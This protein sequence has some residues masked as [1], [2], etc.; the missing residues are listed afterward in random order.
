MKKKYLLLSTFSG[1]L[2]F[3][4]WST[5]PIGTLSLI[6]FIPL[7]FIEYEQL[8]NKKLHSGRT[9]FKYS[10]LSFFIWNLLSTWW[11]Y[12]ATPF[13]AAAAVILNSLFY[14]VVFWIYHITRKHL[15]NR[16][17]DIAFITYWIAFEYIYLNGEISWVWLILGNTFA[18]TPQLVQWYEYTGT[19]GGSLWILLT[20]IFIFRTLECIISDNKCKTIKIKYFRIIA[21]ISLLFIPIIISLYIFKNYKEQGKTAEFVITQPNIDPYND[22]FSGNISPYDQVLLST[23]TAKP[24]ISDSTEYLIAPE[25]AIP[26]GIWENQLEKNYYLKPFFELI[27]TFPSLNIVTGATTYINYKNIKKTATAR[28]II[29][30]N[31]TIFY[32]A[33]NTAIHINN[34]GIE[35]YHKSKLVIGVE[36]IPYPDKLGFLSSLSIDLGGTSGSLGTQKH[37]TVFTS[38]DGKV[39]PGVIIC[40]ES[41]YGEF[42]TEYI[43]KGANILFIITND[44]W[45][46]DTPGYKQHFSFSRLRAIE[47]RRSIA[48]SANTGISG[49]INQKGEVIKKTNWWKKTA[50]ANSLYLNN[51]KTFYVKYGD[52][53]GR[54]A[55][56]STVLILIM[57]FV[58]TIIKKQNK[59]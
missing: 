14:T 54:M 17:G 22:K 23:E 32:D 20:N 56:F 28:M 34:K 49:F 11:I 39:R 46:D 26:V 24:L 55:L 48:R 45:W 16:I 38:F 3:A 21:S 37:R 59:Q 44:G 15:G 42:V 18:N 50:I 53:I 9:I 51:K 43:K 40:Y 19:L 12:F 5:L 13:G 2:L 4:G 10:Y 1:L 30:N 35:T 57:L 31:D 29:N 8:K 47:T 6:S 58:I 27:N 52:Y 25:T 33:F 41:V 36:M 7:L